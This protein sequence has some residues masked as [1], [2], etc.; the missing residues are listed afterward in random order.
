MKRR[1]FF[2]TALALAA[3][4]PLFAAAL[5]GRWDDAAEVLEQASA[6]KQV[7]AA[8]SVRMSDPLMSS[9]IALALDATPGLPRIR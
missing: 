9:A 4:S 2:G 5:R 7:P 1:T 6:D 3:G 8:A